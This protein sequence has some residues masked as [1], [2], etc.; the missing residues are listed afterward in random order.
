MS[1]AEVNAFPCWKA[2]HL[3]VFYHLMLR[4]LDHDLSEACLGYIS[5]VMYTS[6]DKQIHVESKSLLMCHWLVFF[7]PS[8][9][10]E[11]CVFK[12]KS[13]NFL[14]TDIFTLGYV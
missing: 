13:E 10:R 6:D 9:L 5:F 12:S 7:F 2:E 3:S 8:L 1:H 11:S 14:E 4:A